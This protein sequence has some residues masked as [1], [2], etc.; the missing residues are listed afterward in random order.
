MVV[1]LRRSNAHQPCWDPRSHAA[2]LE[3]AE[4]AWAQR[5]EAEKQT[6]GARLEELRQRALADRA[7]AEKSWAA[8]ASEAEARWRRKLD[9]LRDKCAACVGG[10]L[11]GARLIPAGLTFARCK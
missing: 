5:L 2:R 4:S 10:R 11:V 1:W 9:E 7:D 6:A 8:A 3:A